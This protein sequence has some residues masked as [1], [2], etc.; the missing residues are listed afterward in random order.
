MIVEDYFIGDPDELP[1]SKR[2]RDAHGMVHCLVWLYIEKEARGHSVWR[3]GCKVSDS[4][5]TLPQARRFVEKYA[6]ASLRTKEQAAED[7]LRRI[8]EAIHGIEISTTIARLRSRR[9][10]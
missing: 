3:G 4:Y 7:R 2:G 8:K 1:A 9:R 5:M 6:L 10:N